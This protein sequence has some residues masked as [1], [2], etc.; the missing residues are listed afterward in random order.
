MKQVFVDTKDVVWH[1]ACYLIPEYITGKELYNAVN[2]G[3]L[4]AEYG[5]YMY[6]TASA[7]L[8]HKGEPI[9]E[10]LE[11]EKEG[12]KVVFSTDIVKDEALAYE[13]DVSTTENFV[14][15]HTKLPIK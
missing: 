13:V 2:N 15:L 7:F 10:V 4:E 9:V 8:N 11:V 12:N 5:G 1:R 14:I 6:S 3:D